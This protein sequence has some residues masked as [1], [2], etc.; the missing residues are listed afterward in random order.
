M[1]INN[2]GTDQDEF[3]YLAEVVEWIQDGAFDRYG[4]ALNE[5]VAEGHKRLVEGGYVP[6]LHTSIGTGDTGTRKFVPGSFTRDT[7][8]VGAHYQ[9]IDSRGGGA[10]WSGCVIECIK[11]NPARIK[12]KVISQKNSGRKNLVGNPISGPY[13]MIAGEMV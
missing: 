3:D 12:G 1:K 6:K 2:R 8:V 11:A 13:N 9:L 4:D 7:V 10:W 5:L